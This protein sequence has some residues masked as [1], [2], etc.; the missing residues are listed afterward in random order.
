MKSSLDHVSKGFD[1]NRTSVRVWTRGNGSAIGTR[2]AMTFFW[3]VW[4]Y[5]HF[6]RCIMAAASRPS[7]LPSSLPRWNSVDQPDY[8]PLF[9]FPRFTRSL[10]SLCLFY[11]GFFLRVTSLSLLCS[12]PYYPTYNR[13]C[14]RKEKE[15]RGGCVKERRRQRKRQEYRQ[16]SLRAPLVSIR[17][18]VCGFYFKHRA[19]PR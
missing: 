2:S 13:T 19:H 14:V 18:L 9:L 1:V 3:P 8:V 4:P 7:A 15:K 16:L 17:I 6:S 12:H 5:A 10:H 11:I